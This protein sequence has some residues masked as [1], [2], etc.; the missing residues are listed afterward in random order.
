MA[1]PSTQPKNAFKGTISFSD[2]TGTPVTLAVVFTMG[3]T[4]IPTLRQHLNEDVIISARTRFI[5]LAPG[6][7]SYPQV[8]FSAYCGNLVGSSNSAPGSPLEFVHGKGAYAANVSTI[9]ANR[10]MTVDIIVT[11]EGTDWGDAADETITLEDCRV[12]VGWQ[13][14]MDGNV[15]S[16]SAVVLG[17]IVVTN[18]TNTVTYAQAA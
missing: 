9:G 14:S 13:E 3:D 5:G 7:P 12:E 10:R 8:S 16:F 15:L 1:A 4:N 2:G 6:A 18:S 17:N 11:I